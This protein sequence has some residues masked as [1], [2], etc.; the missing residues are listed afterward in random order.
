MYPQTLCGRPVRFSQLDGATVGLW[1]LGRETRALLRVCRQLLRSLRVAVIVGDPTDR[2]QRVEADRLGAALVDEGEAERQLAVCDIIVRSPGVSVYELPLQTARAR[3]TA[4]TTATDLWFG[5]VAE[6]RIVGVTGTKGKST[7]SALIAHMLARQGLRTALAGNIGRPVIDLLLEP[8]YDLYVVELSSY[9]TAD[10]STGPSI[11]VVTNLFPEHLDWHRSHEAY[12]RDKMRLLSLPEV[13]AVV[14]NPHD[15]TVHPW[16]RS[17]TARLVPFGRVDDWRVGPD[18]VEREGRLVLNRRSAPLFG[19]HNLLNLC[20]AATAVEEI[21]GKQVVLPNDLKGMQPLPHRL[22]LLDVEG[23]VTWINDSISTTPE[24]TMAALTSLRGRRVVLIAGG[25]DRG[26][27]F[28]ELGRRLARSE[29]ELV[30]IPSTGARMAAAAV[31]AGMPDGR[32]GVVENLSAAVT[33]AARRAR[34]G[35]V[36]LM[37]PAAASQDHYAN[38]E[39]RGDHFRSLVGWSGSP[40]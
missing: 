27:D 16:L 3:G 9:Q 32:I 40:R 36:V 39:Q 29:V 4:V 20:A 24:S 26:Q 25:L 15:T 7:T 35:T 37:S 31:E 11:A 23:D 19:D 8:A 33:E 2:A 21:T 6:R 18:G 12:R 5:E 14:A 17:L 38:F 10:L 28:R 34:G 1:G 22:E 13:E 30:A